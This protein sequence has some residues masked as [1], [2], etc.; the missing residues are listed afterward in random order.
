VDSTGV[1][2]PDRVSAALFFM[3][4]PM[5][6]LGPRFE[7]ALVYATRLHAG[8]TRKKTG[9]PYI[10]HLLGVTALV[11]QYGTD[12]DEAIAALLHDA[13]EDCGGRPRLGEIRARFG[14]RVARIVE[15]CTDSFEQDPQRKPPWRARK[16]QYIAHVRTAEPSVRLVSVADKVHNAREILA[17]VRAHGDAIWSRFTG[18]KEGSLWYYRALVGAFRDGWAHPLVD[19]LDRTVSELER[20]AAQ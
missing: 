7:E 9:R 18:R 15:G 11:L 2:K 4:N 13:V 10:G 5:P 12:E 19:E 6:S 8:Q 17:D 16:E 20:L 3:A 1:P 14:E